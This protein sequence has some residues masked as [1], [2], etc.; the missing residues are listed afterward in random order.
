M[1]TKNV[2]KNFVTD[3]IPQILIMGLGIV[4]AKV[5]LDCLGESVLGLY[6]LFMQFVSYL[7]IAEGGL[8]SASLAKLYKPIAKEDNVKVK[9]ILNATRN[10]FVIVGIIMLVLG[11]GISFLIPMFI[12]NN[13]FEFSYIQFNFML[14]LLS[15]VVTYFTLF[16]RIAFDAKQKKYKINLLIQGGTILKSL[17]EILILTMGGKITSLFIMFI[18]LNTVINSI[19][20]IKYRKE[21]SYLPKTKEK[22]YSLVKGVKHLL[23]H[24]IGGIIANNI[25]IVIISSTAGLGLAKVVV[26]STYNYIITSLRIVIDKLY[27][28]TTSSIGDLIVKE[29]EKSYKVFL[30]YNSLVNYIAA[31]LAVP[32]YFSIDYFINIWYENKI[33]TSLAISAMFVATFVYMTIRVPLL[34]YTTSAGLFKETK[35]CP[36][37][38]SVINLTLSLILVRI[39]GIPG[40][41]A[42]TLIAL[43]ISEYTI[44]P[45]L[46]HKKIFNK[47]PIRYYTKNILLVL[48]IVVAMLIVTLLKSSIKI[49]NLFMWLVLSGVVFI[50]NMLVTTI[51]YIVIKEASFLNRVKEMFKRKG[52]KV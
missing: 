44:K 52:V 26:Y 12:E 29:K 38:E 51:Y 30:E 21:Y 28:A 5:L 42:A 23:V 32:L 36:I 31:V 9:E 10:V 34:A 37:I 22:D 15:E 2:V 43:L 18:V 35:I 33:G 19:I 11:L 4:K 47:N 16:S 20:V 41:L 3:F 24:K 49:D 50:T 39:F 13:I 40:I 14:F 48:Y 46:L 45:I 25:D 27:G 7:A 17:L 8:A 6:Q 1:R